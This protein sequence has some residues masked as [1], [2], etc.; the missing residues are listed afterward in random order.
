MLLQVVYARIFY[1]V[2]WKAGIIFCMNKA[3]Q[4]RSWEELSLSDIPIKRSS[5]I[6]F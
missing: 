5:V 2:P 4:E 3:W 1:R 6:E